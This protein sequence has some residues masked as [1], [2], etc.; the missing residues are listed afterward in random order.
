MKS[1]LRQPEHPSARSLSHHRAAEANPIDLLAAFRSHEVTSA[2]EAIG[3]RVEATRHGQD[4][5]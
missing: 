2:C 5:T 4:R 3:E 1:G